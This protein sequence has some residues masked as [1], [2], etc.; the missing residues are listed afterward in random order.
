MHSIKQSRPRRRHRGA[1]L[2]YVMAA[3]MTLSGLASLAVDLARVRLTKTQLQGAADSAARAAL[4]E[5]PNGSTAVKNRAVAV[6]GMN[7]ADG[8]AVSISTSDVSLGYWD[9]GSKT[10]TV[11][12]TNPNAVRVIACRT[13]AAGN[14]V[15]LLFGRLLGSNTC[16][17]NVSSIAMLTG[18]TP[19]RVPGFANPWLAGM[20][21]GAYGGSTV[22]GT[23]PENSPIPVT[24]I[25]VTPGSTITFQVTGS[26]ADDPININ[27]AWSP[28]GCSDGTGIRTNDSGYLNGMSN[29][30]TQ[31]GSLAGVFLNNS[32]PNSGSPPA[33][34]DMSSAAAMDYDSISPALKQPFFI[35]DGKRSNGN[36]QSVVVP[37]GATRLFLGMHD[38]INWAN[39]SGYLLVT[40]NGTGAPRAVTVK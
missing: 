12:N 15:P 2:V 38:N 16:N 20:P 31:Q 18:S 3:M 40:F 33:N 1:A 22:S 35:G 27:K 8:S 34:L 26:C 32:A 11:T 29:L 5:I 4:G 23:A 9:S 25:P 17:V 14:A 19:V 7:T 39:N 28:D 36:Q 37:A 10:F 6:A 30:T 24:S 21:N 13:A